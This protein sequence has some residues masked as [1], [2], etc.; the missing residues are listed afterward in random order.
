METLITIA[1]PVYNVEQYLRRCLDSIIN[2]DIA[3]CEILLVNDGSTDNS[4]QICKEYAS[5]NDFIR[6][7][8]QDNQGLASVRNTCIREANG[9]YISFVDSD[10]F[11]IDGAYDNFKR[12]IEKFDADVIVYGCINEYGNVNSDYSYKNSTEVI[13]EF[14][15]QEAIDS[16]FIDPRIEVI[17]CNKVIRK[18]LFD[19]VNY[20]V[21]RL[22][23]DMFTNYKVISKANV[24]VSTSNKYY[25][26]CHRPDSIGGMKYSEKTMDLYRA[27]TEVHEF[28]LNFCDKI[29]N[30]NVGYLHWMI[31]VVNAMIRTDIYD[32]QYI[33]LVKKYARTVRKEILGNKCVGKIRKIQMIIFSYS[34]KIYSVVYKIKKKKYRNY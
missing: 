21:G 5:K 8:N 17:T 16:I 24:I 9:E 29:E 25:V 1:I 30:L 31:V 10:D 11:I 15:P 28:G 14:T 6:L 19:G 32:N 33:C 13:T 3:D 26:Y 34:F 22:Y 27:A 23:E 20:P 2:Q 7:I 18:K 4:L 12:L